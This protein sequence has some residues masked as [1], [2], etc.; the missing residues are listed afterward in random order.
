MPITITFYK[1]SERKPK[2]N[3]SIIWLKNVN[4]YGFEGF[5]PVELNVEYSWEEIDENGDYTGGSYV[6]DQNNPPP[7]VNCKLIILF[8][9]VIAEDDFL[10]CPVEEY[11]KSFD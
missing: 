11:W 7:P 9:A 4:Q 10:W 3:E 2:H 1:V 5:E 8:K 6:Y